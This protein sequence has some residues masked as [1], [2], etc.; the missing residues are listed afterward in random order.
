M[1]AHPLLLVF[2]AAFFFGGSC[3]AQEQIDVVYLKNGSKI[4]GTIIEQVPNK[5]LTIQTRDGSEFVYTFDEIEVI[6][7]ESAEEYRLD[8]MHTEYPELGVN[9]GTPGGLNLA[10]GYWF[11]TVGLRLSGMYLGDIA[12][13]QGNVGF[14]LSDNST[15]SHVLAAVF[16]TSEVERK[17]WTYIGG[18]YELNLSGFFLQ[19]GATIGSGDF[20]SPQ[21]IFQIGYMH[22]FL[23]D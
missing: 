12:G 13:V 23:P 21:L 2:I 1:K 22:R 4:R 15:R 20:T 18:V 3:Y 5:Q 8:L 17:N 9:F 14:K 16:G 10:A 7:K 6:R 11:G 19:A